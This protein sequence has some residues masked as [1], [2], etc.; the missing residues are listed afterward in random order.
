MRLLLD[1]HVFIWAL[2]L[3]KNLSQ[4]AISEL[5]NPDTEAFVSLASAWELWIKHARKPI[6][7]FARVLDG[8]PDAFRMAAALSRMTILDISLQHVAA[9]RSLPHLHGD[10]FDRLLIAQAMHEGLTLVTHDDIFDRYPGL[11]TLKT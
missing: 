7:E 1:S 5:I 3:P 2:A 11:R 10:P 4:R 9:V 6:K 8:G